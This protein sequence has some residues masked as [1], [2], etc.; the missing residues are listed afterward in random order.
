M[1]GGQRT[2]QRTEGRG[3]RT[4]DEGRT[5]ERT[6]DGGRRGEAN[7]YQSASR[8]RDKPSWMAFLKWASLDT[9]KSTPFSKPEAIIRL[10]VVLNFVQS[11]KL[12]PP[13]CS[14]TPNVIS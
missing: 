12:F 1:Y 4:E 14:R 8:E 13:I 7:E 3:R 2:E 5:E 10:S 6:E 11:T 9:N